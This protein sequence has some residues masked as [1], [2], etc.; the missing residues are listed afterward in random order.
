MTEK[1]RN[2]WRRRRHTSA[3]GT[4]S[5][6]G[7]PATKISQPAAP[8]LPA[9]PS[10]LILK[11]DHIGDF[12]LAMR[13]LLELRKAWPNAVITL[14]AGPWNH[15]LA[16]RTGI[17]DRIIDFSFFPESSRDIRRPTAALYS[18]FAE[19]DLGG[20]YDIAIDL[21]Y[22][23]DTRPLLGMVDAKYRVGYAAKSLNF[24]LDLELPTADGQA[25]G[26][27]NCSGSIHTELRMLVLVSLLVSFF[28]QW[29]PH[30]IHQMFPEPGDQAGLGDHCSIVVA[31]GAGKTTS[32]WPLKNFVALCA[33]LTEKTRHNILLVGDSRDIEDGRIISSVLPSDCVRDLT[34]R[35]PIEG[36]PEL[37]SKA[38]LFVGN[39]SGPTHMAA[40]LGVP[41]LCIFSG[42][43]D[44]RVWQPIGSNVKIIRTDIKCS[45]CSLM[46]REQCPIDVKCLTSITVEDVFGAAM[47]MLAGRDG[48]GPRPIARCA[49]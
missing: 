25:T 11:L 14:V 4:N 3:T 7:I 37:L 15:S 1:L 47:D 20:P 41:T 45:P 24:T 5:S 36:L 21:R 23:E 39:D 19:V 13:P 40:K 30:P 34:G 8:I 12:V 16:K 9:Q 32:Q 17:F 28:R 29:E 26:N 2:W 33:A 44:Y 18:K 49:E 35:L 22:D 27:E 31:P 46:R 10:I 43:A 48:D 42:A 6:R 38:I